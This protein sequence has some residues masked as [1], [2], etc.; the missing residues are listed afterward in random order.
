MHHASAESGRT[1]HQRR[2][3]AR[4]FNARGAC[5]PW[6][7]LSDAMLPNVLQ[8]PTGAWYDPVEGPD[9]ELM[10][11]D[12]KPSMLTRNIDTVR[13]GMQRATNGRAGGT[14]RRAAAA[15]SRP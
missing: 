1:R 15:H 8:L 7:T 5:L 9:G 3:H 14:L 6:V 4:V 10:C 12:G 11:G 13:A 2:R